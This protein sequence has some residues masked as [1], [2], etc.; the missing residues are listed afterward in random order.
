LKSAVVGTY[1]VSK[2]FNAPI[3]FVFKWCTDFR[4]DDGKMVGSKNKKRFLERSKKRIVWVSTYK[5][6]GVPGEGLRVVWL[7]PPDAWHFETCGDEYERG[8]TS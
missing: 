5:E 1:K 3:D 4:E 6:D 2:T 7:R 8:A